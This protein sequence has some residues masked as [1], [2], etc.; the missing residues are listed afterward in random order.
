M[1]DKAPPAPDGCVY[2]PWWDDCDGDNG[3]WFVSHFYRGLSAWDGKSGLWEAPG[4]RG[5]YDDIYGREL[6]RLAKENA[7][8]KAENERLTNVIEKGHEEW[9]MNAE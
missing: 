7:E 4:S 6:L 5:H 3:A 1:S 8:L 9:R 2:G